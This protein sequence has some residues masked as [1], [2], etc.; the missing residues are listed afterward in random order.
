MILSFSLMRYNLSD[1]LELTDD[2]LLVHEYRNYIKKFSNYNLAAIYEWLITL[3]ETQLSQLR[4]EYV[5]RNNI[6]YASVNIQIDTNRV[7]CKYLIWKN[8]DCVP[9]RYGCYRD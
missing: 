5:P 4:L 7:S 2:E 9:P 6:Y 1:I 3:T 8:D